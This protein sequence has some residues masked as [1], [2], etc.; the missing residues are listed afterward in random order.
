MAGFHAKTFLKYDD[1]MTP[2][3]AWEN[4]I[5]LIPK[6][7][8]IWSPFYGDGK[9]KEHFKKLGFN[10]IHKKKDFFIYEPKK[11]NIIIDNPPFSCKKEVFT[12]LK[13]LNKPFIIICPSSMI[14][15]LYIRNLFKN[16]IQILI[17]KRRIQFIKDG[18]EKNN[19]CNFEC[20]YYCYKMNL[21]NDI[22]WL[23]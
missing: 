20:F 13:E 11:Y 4:I 19:R 7:S 18:I 22:T 3:E 14:N 12:R 2:F 1:Y 15:T 17:P 21:K 5:H 16:E 6:N 10:I 8:K 9:Q 23:E